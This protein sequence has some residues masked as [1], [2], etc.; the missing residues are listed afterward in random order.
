MIQ[1]LKWDILITKQQIFIGCKQYKAEE[2]F[3]FEDKEISKMHDEALVWWKEH[4]KFIKAAW[5][6]HCKD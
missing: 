2:W 3:K 1:G 4:K 6:L 5:E